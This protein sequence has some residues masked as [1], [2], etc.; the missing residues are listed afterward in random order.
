M[1][2]HKPFKDLHFS[3]AFMFAAVMED[4]DICRGVME[5]ILVIPIKHVTVRSE[6]SLLINSY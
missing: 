3:D 4:E 2:T 1:T 5:R 6:V